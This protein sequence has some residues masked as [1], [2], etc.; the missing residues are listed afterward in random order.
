MASDLRVVVSV[1][2]RFHAFYL[3]DE[4]HRREALE[5]LYTSYPASHAVRYGVPRGRVSGRPSFELANRLTQRYRPGGYDARHLACAAFERW[6]ARRLRAGPDV[7]VGWSGSSL[8][9]LRRAK[10]LGMLTVVERGSTHILHQ[11]DLL[12]D[13]YERLGIDGRLSHPRTVDKELEEYAEADRIA[14][15]TAYVRSTFQ[16]RGIPAHKLIQVPYGVSLESF[17]PESGAGDGFRILHVGSVS[18]RKGCHHLLQA[19]A[20]LNLPGAELHLVGAVAPEMEPFLA[21]YA[22]SGVVVHGAVPQ[23]ELPGH[24]RRASLFC[25]ASLEEGM[26]MVIPQAMACGLPVVATTESGAGELIEPGV[27]GLLLPA[28]EVGALKDALAALHDDAG[29]REAMGVSAAARIAGGYSWADYGRRILGAYRDARLALRA[30]NDDDAEPA[31]ECIE[32][33]DSVDSSG[34]AD[35]A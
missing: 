11:N 32:R 27:Q 2:G 35:A 17:R 24:Y 29:R 3:A 10:A 9:A 28:R 7:F 20:E 33:L 22:G 25:L 5:R 18:V 23:G 1:L 8:A 19:F 16:A 34:S 6:V 30:G 14:V 26:A 13:E 12:R 21:R 15:P 4:L 31:P